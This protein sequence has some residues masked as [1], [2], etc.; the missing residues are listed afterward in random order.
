[1]LRLTSTRHGTLP[2]AVPIS[3][4]FRRPA[5]RG[6]RQPKRA[7]TPPNRADRCQARP[8]IRRASR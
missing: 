5:K 2:R 7:R 4:V 6:D 3:C 1:M 8:A